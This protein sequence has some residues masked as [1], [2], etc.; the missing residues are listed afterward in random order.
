MTLTAYSAYGTLIKRGDGGVGAAVQASRTIGTSNQQIILKA[1]DAGAAGNS[2]TCSIAVSGNNTAFAISVTAGN[3]SITSATDGSAAATTTVLNA[4][5][6]LYQNATF[7]A[8]WQATTGAGNGS[9]VLV[10]GSSAALSGGSDGAEVFNTIDGA[11]NISGPNFSM[12]TIDVTHHTSP[13]NYREVVPSFKSGGEVSFDLIY[14]PA[15]TTHEGLLTDFESRILRNFRIVLPDAGNM[16][17]DFAAYVAGA[18]VQAPIDNALML[19]VKLA[20][21]GAVVRT[22]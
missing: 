7:V 4:I 17:Y 3:V 20:V 19:A 22:A 2:K 13:S 8:N 9:G 14:D 21:T 11:K 1:K 18:E 16:Q 6:N 12:E 10:A 5:Y 15:Q